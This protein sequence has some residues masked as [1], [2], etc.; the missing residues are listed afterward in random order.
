MSC[1]QYGS[2]GFVA[3]PVVNSQL[4]GIADQEVLFT[5]IIAAYSVAMLVIAFY[6]FKIHRLRPPPQQCIES[7]RWMPAGVCKY[8]IHED[9]IQWD[10]VKENWDQLSAKDKDR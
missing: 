10:A 2:Q 9:D 3:G 6:A 4:A 5:V 7:L 1:I 8:T